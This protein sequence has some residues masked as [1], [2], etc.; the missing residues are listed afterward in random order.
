ALGCSPLPPPRGVGALPASPSA[1]GEGS[2]TAPR[3]QLDGAVTLSRTRRLISLSR[4]EPAPGARCSLAGWGIGARGHRGLSPTLQEL[5]VT[6]MDVQICNSSRFWNGE[7][8]PAMLCLQGQPLG[9]APTKVS[10]WGSEGCKARGSGRMFPLSRG[11]APLAL[12]GVP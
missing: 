5:E 6:V 9:S 10:P 1:H 3:P 4:R 12:V 11:D 2:D 8:G 7:I